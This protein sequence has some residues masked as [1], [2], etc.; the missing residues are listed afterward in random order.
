M[1][2]SKYLPSKNMIIPG[3]IISM[4]GILIYNNV[5][6]LKSLLRD[7]TPSA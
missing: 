1:R 6:K 7:R 4:L 5:D 2:V 3:L